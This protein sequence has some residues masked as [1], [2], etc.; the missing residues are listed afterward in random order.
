MAEEKRE[1]VKLKN[2]RLS[3]PSLYRTEL[4]DGDDTGKYAATFLIPKSDKKQLKM[5]KDRMDLVAKEKWGNKV[6]KSVQ[7]CL[8]DG[9]EKDLDGYEGHY[10]VKAS[11]KKAVGTYDRDL[12][13]LNEAEGAD[14][15]YAGCYVN[16][17]I[18]FWAMD[19]K[20]GKKVLCNLFGV[21]FAKNGEPFGSGPVDAE[22]DF[23]DLTDGEEDEESEDD[24]AF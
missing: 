24:F 2:V 11:T 19:N 18:D 5:L 1:R 10:S 23:E 16:A 14:R 15:F 7:Y 12:S 13:L 9:D 20:Y 8:L 21:Q 3:F 22:E 17:S 6:P 4:Y